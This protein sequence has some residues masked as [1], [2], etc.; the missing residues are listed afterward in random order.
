[1]QFMLELEAKTRETSQVDLEI[2]PKPEL[3]NVKT[4]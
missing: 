4:T 1:M 2:Q 3:A